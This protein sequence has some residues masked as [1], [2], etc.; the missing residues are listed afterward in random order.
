MIVIC[1]QC[2]TR[3]LVPQHAIGADG[4]T[5]RCTSCQHEWFQEPEDG[6]APPETFEPP[7]DIEPIP[8]AVLPIPEGSELPV[9]FENIMTE[10]TL[11]HRGP[12]PR[13]MGY[14]AAAGVF[15]LIAG[16]LY[17]L[18]G[19]V[20][21]IWPPSARLYEMVGLSTKLPG[22]GLIFDRVTAAVATTE[23]G[24]KFL[25]VEGVIVNLKSQPV[26]I[27][28]V[29]TALRAAD[30][31]IFDSW[32]LDLPENSAPAGADVPFK[33]SYPE[34]PKDMKEVTVSFRPAEQKPAPVHEEEKKEVAH[35][36]SPVPV[37]EEPP[38]PQQGDAHAA[39][40]EHH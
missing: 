19:P 23:A 17:V 40:P 24:E 7:D 10:G 20:V 5:V 14:A 30:G 2:N 36:E 29:S 28:P 22:E 21:K 34:V 3:Y 18:H 38:A 11:A 1:E 33:T 32:Q 26:D 16:I 39:P 31:G 15:F 9:I 25:N 37:H 35:E 12:Y 13:V 4:R 8:E 6:G 27:P